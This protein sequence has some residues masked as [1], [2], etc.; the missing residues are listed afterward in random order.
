MLQHRYHRLLGLFDFHRLHR[1]QCRQYRPFR[2]QYRLHLRRRMIQKNLL[3]WPLPM[4]TKYLD[5]RLHHLPLRLK[6]P[7]RLL[8][9]RLRLR[10]LKK[11]I[12]I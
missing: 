9:L 10:R 7:L 1:R 6:K 4:Q 12:L 3:K 5:L 8:R 2:L 11:M